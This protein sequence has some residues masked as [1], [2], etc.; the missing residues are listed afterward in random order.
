MVRVTDTSGTQVNIKLKIKK[1][2]FKAHIKLHTQ[3]NL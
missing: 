3:V 1:N 2:W